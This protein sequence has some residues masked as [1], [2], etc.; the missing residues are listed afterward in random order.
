MIVS[1]G[2]S[3]TGPKESEG[4]TVRKI[5]SM[6]LVTI[7]DNDGEKR[8]PNSLFYR[9]AD[10]VKVDSLSPE[11]SVA[12]SISCF[13]VEIQGK[14]VLFDTGNG[15]ARGGKMLERLKAAGITPEEIDFVL[16]THFHGDHVG[17]MLDHGKPVFINAQVY[18][19]DQE[20]TAWEAMDSEGA[21]TAM[22]TMK[23]YDGQLHRFQYTDALPLGIR[24]LAAP[25]HTPGHTVYQVGR[26]FVAGDLIHGFDLQ[27]QDLDI[28]PS[29]DINPD[30]AIKT[31][32]KYINYIRQ[33]QL[34]TAGMHFPANG[35][36]D[37]L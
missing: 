35:I 2:R 31:R 30:Q 1:C 8:M 14:N 7:K 16:L 5:D 13:I 29:Y 37:S 36:K 19:P 12:S 10:S 33:N 32:K 23:I 3:V 28:C 9:D 24:A 22:E 34:I 6:T 17:G 11:G 18:V 4:V 26:L 20:Y 27:I 15:V 25:G 21:A